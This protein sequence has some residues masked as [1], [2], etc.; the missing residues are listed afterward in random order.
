VVLSAAE[1]LG[2]LQIESAIPEL[3]TIA[4]HHWFPPVRQT[5]ER[6]ITVLRTRVPLE[7]HHPGDF[8]SKFFA[9]RNAGSEME[10]INRDEQ[11]S[12]R[13]PLPATPPPVIKVS[14]K[15]KGGPLKEEQSRGVAVPNGYLIGSNR[16]E[17]GGEISFV[18]TKGNV[19]EVS[20]RNTEAIYHAGGSILAVTGLAHLTMNSGFIL[21]VSKSADGRWMAANWRVLPGAPIFSRL[22]E[23]G[24]LFVSCYGGIVMV[25]P[26]GKMRYLTRREVGL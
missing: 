23:D 26:D 8:P 17:W 6:A 2:R 24:S 18:D 3:S 7:H 13:L 15:R 14:I 16:G 4:S 12:I 11:G 5:A 22:L 21:K 1:A 20:G 25:S 19:E 9:Y 10:S